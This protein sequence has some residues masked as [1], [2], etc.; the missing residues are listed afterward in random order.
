VVEKQA[1]WPSRQA[2]NSGSAFTR[3]FDA[4]VA[5]NA[6]APMIAIPYL[7]RERPLIKNKP[8][9]PSGGLMTKFTHPLSRRRII[10][11]AGALA[12]GIAAPALIG[13]RS[14][15]AAYPDRTV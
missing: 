5:S 11:G 14:A 1:D 6:V 10:Q 12:A 15:Y 13:T 9:K 8:P 4:P 3:V 2:V 7:A